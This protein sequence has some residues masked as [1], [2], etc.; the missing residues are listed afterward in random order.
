MDRIITRLGLAE[1]DPELRHDRRGTTVYKIGA[2]ALK[3]T[4]GL[5]A[6]R[7]GEILH[8]LGNQTYRAHGWDDQRSWLT[9][10]WI[11]GT[12]LWNALHH[13]HRGQDSP[14]AKHR[15]LVMTADAARELADL[16]AAGWVHG[17]LQPDHVI[18][19]GDHTHI[20]DLACAQGPADVPFYIH[21]GGLTHTTAPEIADLILSSDDHV[22][23]TPQADIWSLGASLWWSWTRTTPIAYTDPAAGRTA[24]L[25]DICALHRHPDP[26][27]LRPWPFPAFEEAVMAC[28]AA[29][30]QDRP[31]A[32]ELATS[33]P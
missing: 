2:T 32:K 19:D 31:T 20:I 25:T 1:E 9:L 3:I 24:L 33:L 16:H 17:D 18:F 13:A 7:E 6:A 21:R 26:A 15:M 8:L 4:S 29:D 11:N 5:M 14:A 30:P 27:A 12:G 28:L 22:T 10:Q 23:T